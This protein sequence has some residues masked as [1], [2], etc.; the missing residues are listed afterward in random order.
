VSTPCFNPGHNAAFYDIL[1]EN[2]PAH[3]NPEEP[4]VKPNALLIKPMNRQVYR[5]L[6]RAPAL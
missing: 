2:G 1:R 6:I 5:F 3:A 4:L